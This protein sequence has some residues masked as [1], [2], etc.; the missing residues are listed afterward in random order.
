[1]LSLQAESRI[2]F[3]KQLKQLRAQGKMPLVAYGKKGALGS[4]TVSLADFKKVFAQAGEST[5]VSLATPEGEHDALIHDIA[6]DP[7]TTDPVHADLYVIEKGQKVRVK[8]PIE[9]TGT[10]AAVKSLAGVLVKVLQELEVEAEPRNLPH[11][12]VADI[13]K[14]ATFDD[15]IHAKDITLPTGVTLI[16]DAEAVIALVQ[17]PK[18]EKEEDVV[19]VDLSTIE[20][21]KKGKKEEEAIGEPEAATS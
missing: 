16:E 9:F 14:L 17:E 10:S 20:V 5:V 12:L 18:E 4:Y 6:Y 2:Q 8:V 21:E 13:S 19:P 3:G 11:N 7:V 1:M 15:Q